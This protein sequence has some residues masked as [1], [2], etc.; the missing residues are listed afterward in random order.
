MAFLE[1]RLRFMHKDHEVFSFYVDL[2]ENS[3][4]FGKPLKHFE[5]A[6]Y[7]MLELGADLD[8]L[9]WKFFFPRAIPA[10]RP[11]YKKILETTGYSSGF[12]LSFSG[13]GLSLSNHYWFL[14][15]DE[16]LSYKDINFFEH[17]F[18]D[19]FGRA[20]L[21]GDYE[22]LRHS[23]LNV[24]DIVT[25]GYASK[26]WLYEDGPKLYKLGIDPAHCEEAI[27]EALAS[28][29]AKR[30]FGEE[31]ALG[32]ELKRWKD[33]YASVCAPLASMN[34]ELVPLS[35]VLPLSLREMVRD[36][37]KRSFDDS[38]FAKLSEAGFPTLKEQF[39]KL[40]CLRS[41]SFI[42]DLH[43]GNLALLKNLEDGSLR[44]APFYDLA[45]AFG[46]SKRGKALLSN[47]NEGTLFLVYFL[48]GGLDPKWDYSWYDPKRLEGFEEEM[49]LELGKSEFYT[50][51]LIE[52]IVRVYA[53]QKEALD[54]LAKKR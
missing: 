36:P 15:D 5:E 39:V 48:F 30:L 2:E 3:L 47:L 33:T 54:D 1:Q 45:G 12:A 29:L 21:N 31:G 19:S 8:A 38:F 18:D 50:P 44:P 34:E 52:N 27:G 51:E 49:R 28:S 53:R 16:D 7:G 25:P 13:H 4:R 35:S 26:G 46:G 37:A 10:E 20:L 32:Y 9:L 24:P 6:P 17:P 43:F 11:G 22:A 42:S 40:S 23:D 14:R 41:L